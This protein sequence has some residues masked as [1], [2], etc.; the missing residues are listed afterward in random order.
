MELKLD[1]EYQLCIDGILVGCWSHN[2]SVRTAKEYRDGAFDHFVQA[3]EENVVR[4]D[5]KIEG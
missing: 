3:G 4:T 2:D 1:V 5:M